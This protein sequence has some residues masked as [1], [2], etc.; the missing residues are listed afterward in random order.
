M[1]DV[2][3]LLQYQLDNIKTKLKSTCMKYHNSKTASKYKKVTDRLSKNNNIIII[4]QDK[5]RGIVIL[6]CTKYIDKC[7][8]MLATK[9][10]SKLDYDPTSKLESK[11]QRT[12]RKIKSKLPEK[13]H[14]KLYPTGS[15]SGK[16]YGNVKV[17]KLSTNNVNDLTLRPILSNIGTASYETAKYL[18]IS[19]AP[20][21]NSEF[22][23]NNTKEFVK[24]IQKDIRYKMVSFEV[25]SLFTN[26]PLEETIEIIFKRIYVNKDITTDI[27][28]QEMK[29]LLILCTKNV[30]FTFNNETYIQ[31]DCVAMGSPL[32]PV[33][34]N[35]F[36]VELETSVIP[37]LSNKVKLWKRF[38]DDTYCLARSEYIDNILLVLNS[39]HK[40]M[41]FTT[42]I[43]KDNTILFLDILIIP[44]PGKIEIKSIGKRHVYE[45]VFFCTYKLEM[46]NC[47]NFSTKSTYQLLN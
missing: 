27:P 10:F 34:A 31:V 23:I 24:Y 16:F 20:L 44:K 33:L 19:L 30:H 5:G 45:L 38:V 12:L 40:N 26:V 17:H 22:T 28:K 25:A 37:N 15:W 47:K 39:F 7:L 2:F 35:I 32:G 9:Q 14:K 3:D 6:D 43:E 36:M 42:E 11:V 46:G 29:E 1:N 8:S 4:K 18:T 41:K 21:S 13:F